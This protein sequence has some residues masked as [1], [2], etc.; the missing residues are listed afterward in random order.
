[1]N[2]NIF[3]IT[4]MTFTFIF[5]YAVLKL[6]NTP[7]FTAKNGLDLLTF[8]FTL[9]ILLGLSSF[10]NN[11]KMFDSTKYL[12]NLKTTSGFFKRP[13]IKVKKLRNRIT[14]LNYRHFDLD[15]FK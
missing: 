8:L 1:M 3:K 4:F 2:K 13:K 9:S 5:Y 7:I 11:E 15:N 14:L 12:K 10:F 6:T